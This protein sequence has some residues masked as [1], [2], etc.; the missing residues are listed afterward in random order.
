ME[1]NDGQKN[2]GDELK[3]SWLLR[4]ARGGRGGGQGENRG[5]K[6]KLEASS[7]IRFNS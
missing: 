3:L 5:N 2:G 4:L 6:L 7:L 1:G